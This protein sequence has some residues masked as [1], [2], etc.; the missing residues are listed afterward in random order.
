V[1]VVPVG[2]VLEFQSLQLP[3]LIVSMYPQVFEVVGVQDCLDGCC[4]CVFRISRG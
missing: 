4:I 2:K 1:V 3:N